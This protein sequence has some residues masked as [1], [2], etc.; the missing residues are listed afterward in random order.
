M[1]SFDERKNALETKFVLDAAKE[2][3]VAA[4]RN[5]ALGLWVADI[6]GHTDPDKYA[7][8]VIASD[9]EEA[10]DDDVFR[11]VKS[12]LA[13]AGAD[14]SDEAIREKMAALLSEARTSVYESE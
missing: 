9:M 6:I 10:G 5:K 1:S 13:T 4:K 7:L 12:D 3:K 2:F 14:I 11:K 8:E